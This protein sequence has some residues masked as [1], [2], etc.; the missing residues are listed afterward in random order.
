MIP[1]PLIDEVRERA[2]IVEVIGE[3]LTLK[4]S[5]KEFKALCPF[6]NEKTPSFYVVPAKNF[7]KCFGCGESGD[8]FTFLMK[9]HGLSFTD[10]V[11]QIAERVGVEIPRYDAA[12]QQDEPHKALHEAISFAA[13]F[14]QRTLHE[15]AG[16]RARTYLATRGVP[17]EAVARF[18]IGCAPDS[19]Q[20]L[21]EAAHRHGIE[22]DV[23]LEAGLIKQSERAGSEPYD[24]FRNR[25]VFPIMAVSGRIVAFGGRVLT[26]AD[27]P[28][29]LN[30]PET[31]IYHKGAM[32]YG[33]NWSRNAIRREGAALVVEGYMDYVSLAARGVEHVVAGMGTAITPEQ[34]NL[35]ARYA[36]RALLLYDSDTAGLRATFKTA[37]A[38]LRAGVHPLVVALPEGED[39]DSLVRKGGAAA[40][41]PHLD[42]AV[43]VLE[44]KLRILEERGFFDDID[45]AR[46]ALD[47]VLPTIRAAVDP[48][49]RDIYVGR[50]AL[51]IGVTRETLEEELAAGGGRE[52]SGQ[53]RERARRPPPRRVPE[54][55]VEALRRKHGDEQLLVLLLARDPDR[56][57]AARAQL[58]ELELSD[59]LYREIYGA[60]LAGQAESLS[61]PA[62]ERLLALQADGGDIVDADRSFADAVANIYRHG[63][64]LQL[65]QINLRIERPRAGDSPDELLR[66]KR[67][68]LDQLR[69]LPDQLGFK[70]APRW[71]NRRRP[72]G[73]PAAPDMEE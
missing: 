57:E 45:G 3:H 26:S 25:L 73:N 40:L 72:G 19:W 53:W 44:T 18:G 8:V 7:Y 58:G 63:L 68:L 9:R 70:R 52:D 23:L 41:K 13:D 46:R 38:L 2:D 21:R 47:R 62:A 14:F 29:Y 39:P 56:I 51:R 37:D 12:E 30:S 54:P 4:R 69:A 66:L 33:L 71:G 10:A 31:P 36:G 6:H 61:G 20:G 16:E 17:D 35:L 67:D 32:L 5:G 34:A 1:D 24:R 55:V 49:L 50:V 48:A 27:Q 11:R 15:P 43:D 60:L 65:D 28:K 42:A 59:P 22:D 64:N